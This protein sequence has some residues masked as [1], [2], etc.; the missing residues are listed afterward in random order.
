MSARLQ[1]GRA[2]SAADLSL[3]AVGLPIA[4]AGAYIG[5][6]SLPRKLVVPG[7][8]NEARIA[9]VVPSHNEEANVAAT[10]S[11]LLATKYPTDRRRVIVVADNCSDETARV[12][13]EAGAEVFERVDTSKRGKGYALDFAFRRLLKEGWADVVAVVDADTIVQTNLLSAFAARFALGE[14]AC[15]ANYEVRNPDDSWRTRLMHIAFTAF[16]EVRGTGREAMHL[17]AGLRGNGMAFSALTLSRVPHQAFSVVEDLEYGVM[18][19][20]EGI[21]VAYVHES[22]VSGDMPVDADSSVSQRERWEHG[23]STLR[24][25]YLPRLLTKGVTRRSAVLLDIAADVALPPLG[26][27]ALPAAGGF[28]AS[29]AVWVAQ[30]A[31]GHRAWSPIVF[32]VGVVGIGINVAEGWR[33]SGAGLAGIA[34]L[35]KV[36]SYLAWKATGKSDTA[37]AAEQGEWVRTKR[38][39]EGGAS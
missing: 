7:T 3:A 8:S 27:V 21:R 28:A 17:S 29:V 26:K 12:A 6:I 39:N 19:G 14:Q 37:S 22:T 30:R 34:D 35:A 11:S 20:L 23:R 5:L 10:I 9:V 36:P 2:I 13:R 16:H 33:R 31:L 1:L 32:G 25:M 15:Q 18:L 4:V 24:R 38:S